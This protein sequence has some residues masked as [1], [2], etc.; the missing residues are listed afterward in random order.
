M[1]DSYDLI[2]QCGLIESC[3]LSRLTEDIALR[4]SV[5]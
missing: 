1:T 4:H 5:P 3:C 2:L